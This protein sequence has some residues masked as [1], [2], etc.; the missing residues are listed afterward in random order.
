[1]KDILLLSPDRKQATDHCSG[2][3]CVDKDEFDSDK[4]LLKDFL[5]FFKEL[6]TQLNTPIE[7]LLKKVD[8]SLMV[9]GALSPTPK[10]H[11]QVSSAIT[12]PPP[13]LS[14]KF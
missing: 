6:P 5:S 2:T 7:H 8:K 13:L 10:T 3:A 11:V 1:M 12:C 9:S 14:S 4:L